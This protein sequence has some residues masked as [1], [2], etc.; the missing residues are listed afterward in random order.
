MPSQFDHVLSLLLPFIIVALF[1]AMTYYWFSNQKKANNMNSSQNSIRI[2]L[3]LSVSLG[4]Y[5]PQLKYEPEKK[6]NHQPSSEIETSPCRISLEQIDLEK[7]NP[8]EPEIDANRIERKSDNPQLDGS[9]R[10]NLVENREP[11]SGKPFV[12]NSKSENQQ[13]DVSTQNTQM[14][15]LMNTLTELHAKTEHWMKPKAEEPCTDDPS[16]PEDSVN[17]GV[18]IA[19]LVAFCRTFNLYEV[20]TGDVLRNYVVPFT[21]ESRCRFVELKAM[22]ESG[23]VGEARTFISHCFNAPFGALVA[24][25]CDGGAD[26][27]RRVWVDIFAVRQWPSSKNDLHFEKVIAQCPSFM[28]VCPSL[29]EVREMSYEDM[30]SRRYPAAA[31]ARVPFFRI[32]CLYELFYAAVEGKSIVIKVGSFRLEES[33]GQQMVRF[34]ADE[35]I[36]ERMYYA[37]DVSDA[38]ATVAS[39]KAM[40]FDK[41]LSYEGGLAGCNSRVRGVLNGAIEACE[42]PDLLCAVCGDAAA[43]AVVRGQAGKFFIIAAAGGFQT[44]IEGQV[45]TVKH[46]Y[47]RSVC[48]HVYQ[49]IFY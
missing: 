6:T 21:S 27:T 14:D 15:F 40:I 18:T 38:E 3:K 16:V 23:M 34:E 42:H 11:E 20:T 36:L 8:G 33:D 5:K 35:K 9:G 43:M 4:Y 26:L 41:I 49:F 12:S 19:F 13:I 39:D 1:L 44:V 25:L 28:V 47:N 30:M 32:W 2:K 45:N 7:E 29:H 10:S 37:I 31:K 46:E 24:A 22:Q 48:I 17:R